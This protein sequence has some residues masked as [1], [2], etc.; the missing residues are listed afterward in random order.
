MKMKKY[1]LL[2]T[3][4]FA[5]GGIAFSEE[6][7]NIELPE[8]TTVIKGETVTAGIDSLPDFNDV[9]PEQNGSGDVVPVLPEVEIKDGGTIEDV[10]NG[11]SEKD[12]YAEGQMGGGYPSVF[13]GDFSVYRLDGAD[14]FK[15]AFHHNSS[16]GYAGNGLIKGYNSR[17]TYM[18]V[19][20]SFLLNQL[21]FE[22]G[23]LYQTTGQ[24]LQNKVENIGD[25]N[26][27]LISG[28]GKIVWNLP[29]GFAL[30][31]DIFADL[32]NRYADVAT[33]KTFNAPE[34]VKRVSVYDV[35][36]NIFG[37]WK[38]SGFDIGLSGNCWL[39]GITPCSSDVYNR[40]D[41][42]FHFLWEN[43]KIKL[44][45]NADVVFGNT[46]EGEKVIAPFCAG[47]DSSIP[48][49]FSTR[50][51]GFALEGGLCSER[52]SINEL[53]KNYKFTGF[54]AMPYETSEWYGKMD[55]SL[56]LKT[57]F[58]IK[59]ALDFRTSAFGNGRFVPDYTLGSE[60]Y[61]IYSFVRKNVTMFSTKFDLAYHYKLLSVTAGWYSNWLDVPV[62]E[63]SQMIL[64]NLS[65]QSQTSAWGVD[66][67][68][69]F[70]FGD[71]VEVPV[72][73][74]S[75]FY[76]VTPAVRIVLAAEDIVELLSRSSRTYAGQYIAE[77]GNVSILVKFFF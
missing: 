68:G 52:N 15:L 41:F 54:S 45:A 71:D 20:R 24:G 32:Y 49:Y 67:L 21:A 57:S 60:T 34:W 50:N 47:L 26:N 5:F 8:V 37:N 59:A 72:L 51:L 73:N 43:L 6:Q 7:E 75:A 18:S 40:A 16:S 62:M 12:I 55:L 9:L 38:A 31:A 13:K 39:G 76:R 65:L 53:E 4:I 42:G 58:T 1:L 30:G 25:I 36:P 22:L 17:D 33:Q 27:D 35:T 77:G 46:L 64:L 23:G 44:Y 28:N 61:G 10:K 19:S 29:K 11:A 63:A 56:P 14:P 3:T 48:V 2:I 69:K 74:M 70:I 66:I